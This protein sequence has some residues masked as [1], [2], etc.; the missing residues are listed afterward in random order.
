M[1]VLTKHNKDMIT[2]K[3]F[4]RHGN[5]FKTIQFDNLQHAME[6]A[7]HMFS[8]GYA[9]QVITEDGNIYAEYE[10]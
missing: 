8:H 9:V 1:P 7:E 3:L 2:L 5:C 6:G 4:N 10:N